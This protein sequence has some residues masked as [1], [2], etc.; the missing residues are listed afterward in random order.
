MASQRTWRWPAFLLGLVGCFVALLGWSFH[1]ASSRVSPVIDRNRPAEATLPI[2]NDAWSLGIDVASARLTVRIDDRNGRPVTGAVTHLLL[3]AGSALP[4][5][6]L[7]EG[8]GGRYTALLPA[9]LA[10]PAS[11]LLEIRKGPNRVVRALVLG[12]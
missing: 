8:P 12:P 11:A 4:S 5:L 6:A 7:A 2:P 1:W 10:R 9:A 3:P